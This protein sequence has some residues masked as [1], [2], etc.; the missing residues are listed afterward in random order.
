MSIIEGKIK[1]NENNSENQ[2]DMKNKEIETLK[3]ESIS[4][5]KELIKKLLEK[6]LNNSLL[7]LESNS[8]NHISSLK[9][10]SKSFNDFSKLINNLIKNVEETKKKKDKGKKSQIMKKNRKST[11]E[12]QHLKTR[13]R[14]IESNL[15]KFKNKLALGNIANNKKTNNNM[16]NIKKGNLNTKNLG[17]RTY[18]TFRL[19]EDERTKKLKKSQYFGYITTQNLKKI[20]VKKEPIT[21]R[22]RFNTKIKD[23]DIDKTFTQ[24]NTISLE[25]FTNKVNTKTKN[26]EYV[27]EKNNHSNTMILN[28]L[29]DIDE[30]KEKYSINKT[31]KINK[32]KEIK[33]IIYKTDKKSS[34]I[35]L[36]NQLDKATEKKNKVNNNKNQVV[37]EK[38]KEETESQ[39]NEINKIV[40][41]A[42][43][44]V[45][46]N[47]ILF[48]ENTKIRRYSIKQDRTPRLLEGKIENNSKS[49]INA[50]KDVN[51]K[52]IDK[53]NSKNNIGENNENNENK[54]TKD[55]N[56]I[57]DTKEINETNKHNNILNQNISEKNNNKNTNKND[58]SLNNINNYKMIFKV[59]EK[60]K[61]N[62]IL[63][64]KKNRSPPSIKCVNNIFRINNNE[65]KYNKSFKENIRKINI[66]E[67][68]K[69]DILEKKKDSN[70]E[71][72][73]FD[74]N[75][76]IINNKDIIKKIRIKMKEKADKI[77]IQKQKENNENEL[78]S[79][80]DKNKNI[81]DN[82]Q[83]NS[84]EKNNIEQLNNKDSFKKIKENINNFDINN[85]LTTNKSEKILIKFK[86]NNNNKSLNKS[87]KSCKNYFK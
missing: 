47:L 71:Y 20:N 9:V 54:E 68:K 33:Q 59:F 60:D 64:I 28:R 87:S 16:N 29:S 63:S 36:N 82:Q 5:V 51:I 75:I 6:S 23:K 78:L 8:I 34:F 2:I 14:T 76:N 18:T 43:N 72:K 52:E 44:N 49:F 81:I 3:K 84:N 12:Q 77:N 65:I 50:I 85:N 32:H 74:Q 42:V 48:S 70:E 41:N 56:N 46:Q 73:E 38:E 31:K 26:I 80:T 86:I 53:K 21:P 67:N 25:S 4:S 55:S 17:K 13:S 30:R 45:N 37:K 83:I 57:S 19:N 40:N 58:V 35:K 24:N 39:V 11:T 79:E 61:N 66:N 15:N 62:E 10:S 1:S 7:K 69:K 27:Y 22:G